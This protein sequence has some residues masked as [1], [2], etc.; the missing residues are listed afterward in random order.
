MSDVAGTT[1]PSMSPMPAIMP[2]TA[3]A[4]TAAA[5]AAAAAA[6][7]VT[8][9]ADTLVSVTAAPSG[10]DS[11]FT[12]PAVFTSSA[13]R[14]GQCG[15]TGNMDGVAVTAASHS[16]ATP[17]ALATSVSAG[18][19]GS[20][21]TPTLSPSED[22]S[23]DSDSD[24]EHDSRMPSASPLRMGTLLQ[25][26]VRNA[27][28]S[29]GW[30]PSVCGDEYDAC[31]SFLKMQVRM[32]VHA[33]LACSFGLLAV[34]PCTHARAHTHIHTYFHARILSHTLT[35]ALTL[36][37]FLILSQQNSMA[38]L[39][40]IIDGLNAYIAAQ[41][42]LGHG[43]LETFTDEE[44]AAIA[45]SVKNIKIVCLGLVQLKRL[46]LGHENGVKVYQVRRFY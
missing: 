46:D 35:N 7:P 12:P 22:R 45:P 19:G 18:A 27:A 4:T 39:N 42:H 37:L 44:I 9:A 31:P 33:V 6:S 13:L 30:I 8:P 36:C 10:S 34:F 25:P 5:T 20:P 38:V 41:Q 15:S 21:E 1:S 2:H 17:A 16:P 40:T 29:E 14:Y 3:V 24:T 28:A 43:R 23:Y 11:P 26:R 32:R